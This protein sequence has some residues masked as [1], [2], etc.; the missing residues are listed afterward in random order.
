MATFRT[1]AEVLT[2]DHIQYKM[3]KAGIKKNPPGHLLQ[4]LLERTGGVYEVQHVLPDRVKEEIRKVAELSS[5]QELLR[6]ASLPRIPVS[7]E[8]FRHADPKTT[9]IVLGHILSYTEDES[10]RLGLTHK[11]PLDPR[12]TIET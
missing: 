1:Y 2:P 10:E 5:D 3:Y 4:T 11:G 9:R 7:L 6:I 8:Q 12:N